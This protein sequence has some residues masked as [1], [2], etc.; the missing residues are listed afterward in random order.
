MAKAKILKRQTNAPPS[1]LGTQTILHLTDIHFGWEGDGSSGEADRKVCLNGMLAEL[2]NL[3]AA[4]KP[5]IICLTGDIA[6]RGSKSDY[7]AAKKWLNELL[8][9]CGLTYCQLVVCP[10]NHDVIRSKA[11]KLPRPESTKDA[12]TVLSLPIAEHFEAPFSEFISFCK[13]TGMPSLKFANIRLN[14][15]ASEQ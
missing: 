10:G 2:K 5:T 15:L 8:K 1:K 6:W 13:K 3:E 4:W 12:D 9:V 11:E 14:S 7:Q